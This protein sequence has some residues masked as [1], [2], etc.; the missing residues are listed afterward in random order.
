MK[1]LCCLLLALALL[2]PAAAL[3]A[4]HPDYYA[5]EV[6]DASGNV[7]MYIVEDLKDQAPDYAAL[8][9]YTVEY[10]DYSLIELEEEYARLRSLDFPEGLINGMDLGVAYNRVIVY[11]TIPS[12]DNI[13]L[14]EQ[15][16]GNSSMIRFEA[17]LP[18]VEEDSPG[19]VEQD[20][21]GGDVSEGTFDWCL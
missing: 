14:F 16:A 6:R 18:D 11:M 20:P 12:E 1:R 3:A 19:E 21:E 2:L 17:S 4:E 5:G 13:A 9:G 15:T 7:T 10:V 8:P